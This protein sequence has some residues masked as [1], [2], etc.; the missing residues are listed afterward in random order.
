MRSCHFCDVAIPPD[1]DRYDTAVC[2]LCANAIEDVMFRVMQD[3]D[4]RGT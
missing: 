2:Q 1:Y 4:R 3:R